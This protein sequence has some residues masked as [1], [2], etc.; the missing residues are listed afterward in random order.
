MKK[1]EFCFSSNGTPWCYCALAHAVFEIYAKVGVESKGICN[2]E[3][4]IH[5]CFRCRRKV[6]QCW[7]AQLYFLTLLLHSFEI[8]AYFLFKF[9]EIWFVV[10]MH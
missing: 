5:Y 8:Y 10:S 4:C 1:A 6:V 3:I 2:F 7:L 9:C